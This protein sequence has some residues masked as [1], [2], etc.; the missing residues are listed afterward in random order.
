MAHEGVVQPLQAAGR[1]YLHKRLSSLPKNWRS[2]AA[3][4]DEFE[5]TLVLSKL[6]TPLFQALASDEYRE[7]RDVVFSRIASRPHAV[8]VF[9]D[10]LSG[11]SIAS[12]KVWDVNAFHSYDDYR[13]RVWL[14]D[15]PTLRAGLEYINRQPLNI[16]PYKTRAQVTLA[17]QAS[18]EDAEKGLLFRLYVPSGRL[19][20]DEVDR[21]LVLFRDYLAR[22]AKVS[23]RLDHSR[24]DRGVIYAFH[25]DPSDHKPGE[26]SSAFDEFSQLMD[27]S[28]A[29]PSAAERILQNRDIDIQEIHGI[30]EK[31][32]REARRLQ[33]DMRHARESKVLAIRHRLETELSD[34]FEGELSPQSISTIVNSIVP[35][36]DSLF[37]LEQA[38]QAQL[39]L[40]GDLTVNIR[41][42]IITHVE[43]VVAQEIRGDVFFAREDERLL[44]LFRSH[45]GESAAELTSSLHELNDRSVAAPRRTTAAQKIKAFL[46]R[47][48]GVASDVGTGLLQSY[49]EKKLLGP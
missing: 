27:L 26:L 5:V 7:V 44:E 25:G 46:Y 47:V 21:L 38:P 49:I 14:H 41:P 17:A 45:G 32:S 13:V 40:V 28:V 8:F 4:F 19:W 37:Q 36:A 11:E 15:V 3:V 2:I 24:T 20:Q 10:L 31:Y 30:I 1:R 18:L 48:G 23:V 42:Q 22:I 16:L 9:E 35:R 43:G 12:A 33:I 34:T 6:T 29:D 39:K